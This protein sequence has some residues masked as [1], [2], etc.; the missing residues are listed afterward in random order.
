[1]I[2]QQNIEFKTRQHWKIKQKKQKERGILPQ[3]KQ[4]GTQTKIV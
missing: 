3:R 1:M 4:I 2:I